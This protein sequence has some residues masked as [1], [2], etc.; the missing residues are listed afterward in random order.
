[1]TR[2]PEPDS[3]RPFP[4]ARRG[5]AVIAP[6]IAYASLRPFH[7]WRD[8]GRHAFA[9]LTAATEF[10]S[11]F[12]ALLNIVG[13]LLLAFC[14]TLALFPRIRGRR[15]LL[16]GTLG[17]A[18]C[19]V[20]V[21]AIQ[22]YL[23]GRFPSR[24]DVAM[25]TFGAL[26][27]AAL[28][29]WLTPWLMDHRGGRRLRQRWLTSGH[30]TEFGLLVLA[31]WFVA[32]F[33]QRTILFGTGDLRGNLEVTVDWSVHPTVYGVSEVF[34]IVANL[35]AAGIVLRLVLAD[36]VVR[37]VRVGWVLALVA[38][39][40]LA[41]V[42]AQLAFW[43]AGAVWQWI[44]PATPIGLAGGA[45]LA[46]FMLGWSRRTAAITALA[47]LAAGVIVVNLTPPDP[48][49]WLQPHAPRERV[50]IAL[51]LVARYAAKAW[52]FAAIAF[53]ALASRAPGP[54]QAANTQEPRPP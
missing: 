53:L 20:A 10:G 49:L 22:T 39:S 40:L 5:L 18:A 23:P 34:V 24:V 3:V 25:N 6:V 14:L 9:Y 47:L 27:G 21:E 1:M 12:D 19:S 15:A 16:I 2:A 31:A 48:A 30:A 35:A 38:A 50:L 41:R 8:P 33:A 37:V 52:P 32:M 45:L 4:L 11:P 29:V 7:D 28:A 13:Y 42:I 51:A 17:P 36:Q 46:W 26:L 44:T 43:R 54:R